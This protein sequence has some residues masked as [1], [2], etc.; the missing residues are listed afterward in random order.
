MPLITLTIDGVRVEVPAGSTLLQAAR[1]AGIDIPT[2]CHRDDLPPS[3]TCSVC[4]VRVRGQRR[5]TPSC[6]IRAEEGMEVESETPEVRSARKTALEL[7]LSDHT[8]DCL[9]PCQTVCPAHMDIPRMTRLIAAGRFREALVTVKERIALPAV[10]GYICPELCE[11]GCRRA[12]LEG[13]VSVCALKRFVA[14]LDLSSGAPYLPLKLPATGKRVAILGAGP[15][16]LAA[17]YYLLQQGHA[18]AIIDEHPAAGGALRYEVPEDRL[19]RRVLDAE[20]EVI[21]ALGATFELG[22][23]VASAA[24][25]LAESDAVLV[26]VGAGAGDPAPRLGLEVGEH[27]LVVDRHTLMAATPGVF[28]AGAC[29]AATRH[30]VRSVASGRAAALSLSRYLAGG[31]AGSSAGGPTFNLL[32]GKLGQPELARLLH[33]SP[34]TPRVDPARAVE[35]LSEAEARAEA[36]RCLRCECGAPVQCRL[37][38][39][40]QE[41]GAQPGRFRG[42]RRHSEPDESHPAVVFDSGKCISCGICVRIAEEHREPLGLTYLGRGFTV[43]VGVPFSSALS[44]GLRLVALRCADA[45]PTGALVPRPE[46]TASDVS[47]D[48]AERGGAPS[49]ASSHTTESEA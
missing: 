48:A 27:G 37:R 16:G 9:G 15:A 5:L 17:A 22:R 23:T 43:R 13:A 11:K 42:E 25:L 6:S 29:V 31:E 44:E 2:L 40:A 19:P 4:V 20:V 35:G 24:D 47:G 33:I 30:A 39:Y 49:S 1:A 26:A 46:V 8:G 18:C 36:A 14:E 38:R 12:Q 45:C 3:A 41:Y 32:H 28:A 34:P 10:L 7:L 21:R